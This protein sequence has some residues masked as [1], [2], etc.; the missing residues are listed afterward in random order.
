MTYLYPVALRSTLD[1]PKRL[2]P[3]FARLLVGAKQHRLVANGHLRQCSG[4]LYSGN[5][6]LLP[7]LLDEALHEPELTQ[8]N[9]I[10]NP[11]FEIGNALVVNDFRARQHHLF[12]FLSRR[13]LNSRQH[14]SLSRR[15]EQNC[16]TTPPRPSGTSDAVNVSL[17]VVGN[18]VVDD[19]TNSVYIEA[20]CCD[21]GGDQYIQ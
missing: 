11:L 6:V 3:G 15:N 10:R 7:V 13:L 16:V 9:R 8:A 14:A 20:T 12:D 5:I 4:D 19:M 17:G 2:H 18:I 21:I 1:I